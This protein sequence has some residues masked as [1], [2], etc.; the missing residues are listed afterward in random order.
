MT[1][2]SPTDADR[3]PVIEVERRDDGV[4]VL[5]WRD[6][7][8]RFH[9]ASVARWHE[10]LDEL[11]AAEGPLALV[12]VGDGRFFSNGLDLDGFAADPDAAS[13]V[14]DGVHRLLGRLL[15]F[16]AI[17][18][19]ALNGHVFAAGAMLACCADLRVMREDRGYWCLPEADLGLPLTEPMFAAVTAR[20]P[21]ATAA[22]AMNTARRYTA[23]E[24]LAAGIVEHTAPDEEVLD[25][26]IALAAPL[27]T[28]DRKVIATHKRMLFG[29]AARTCGV[30]P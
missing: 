1:A 23:P 14:V 27:A 16:P 12:V 29:D 24:A 2:D 30:T 17:V 11:E 7:E 10:V 8:N 4:A 19:A 28:K 20:L 9:R 22:E 21:V 3:G 15:T 6:G 5:R 26:A 25:R 18:V 13:E